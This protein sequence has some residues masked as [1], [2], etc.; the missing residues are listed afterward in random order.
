LCAN[1]DRAE[2]ERNLGM[3][4]L[5]IISDV[6]CPW[7]FIG[8]RRLDIAIEAVRQEFP[9]FDCQKRWR[10]FFLNPNT[11]PEG[12]PYLPFLIQ[13]FGALE[14][15]HGLFQRIR[16]AGQVYGLD[17]NFEKIQVRANTLQ[18]HRLI[19]WAQQQGDA[20]ALVERLFIAQFQ[21]GLNVGDTEMLIQLA[22][23]CGYDSEA[24][25][26]YLASNQ[27]ADLI[28]QMEKESRAWGVSAVPTFV[29]D[30]KL[31]VPGA[32]DPK[33]LADAIRQVLVNKHNSN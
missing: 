18:S 5:E 4:T 22:G 21:E 14:T 17:Y 16:Q 20:Q 9:D 3:I 27:D 12:E 15:V 10:P 8:L 7:C 19:H 30:R 24:A 31:M 6:V 25:G 32:E 13:K 33:V 26:S 2:I 28:R 23:K 29:V 11:P 1:I